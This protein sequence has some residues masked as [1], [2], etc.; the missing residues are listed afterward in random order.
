MNLYFEMYSGIAGDMTIG[1]LLDLKDNRDIL[2]EG[3]NSLGLSGYELVFERVLKNGISAFNFDV[4]LTD[5][6]TNHENEHE[7]KSDHKH[8]NNHHHNH[9]HAHEHKHHHSHYHS[10]RNLSEISKI[11]LNSKISQRAKEYSLGIFNIL[12]DA[13]ALAHGIDKEDVH[14]HEVGAIDSIVDIVGVSILLDAMDVNNIYFSSIT[15][16][17]GSNKCAH[18]YMP[19]P[20]PAVVNILKDTNIKINIIDEYSEH[21]TPTGAAIVRYFN[22]NLKLENFAI[23]NVGLGAGN[24]N[25]K[26]STNILR[27]FEIEEDSK[28]K[29]H[30][31]ETNIDDTTP[32]NLGFVMEKLLPLSLDVFF[33]PIY[34]KKNRPGYKLSVIYSKNYEEIKDIIFKNTTTIGFRII[35]I[36]RETL[37]REE[38]KITYLNK[39]YF[40]KICRY[41]DETF[42]YPEYES[43]K[44]LAQNEDISIK[45]A[46]EKLKK[47]Y[48]R[49]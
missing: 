2:V 15:E 5:E 16:G 46:F 42:I 9:G 19:I 37:E 8:D 26:N 47:L 4:I 29:L 40:L 33:T 39:D 36:T 43:A 22:K 34:M 20:V 3:L 1:A 25:F 35:E 10:H 44:K 6:N 13:E 30:L 24:K 49:N 17:V 18:G 14:F 28:K 38:K 41:K 23:K 31:I 27:I 32:E 48:E 21:I 45:D 7:H 11:I 12:A